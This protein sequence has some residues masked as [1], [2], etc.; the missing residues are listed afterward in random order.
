MNNILQILSGGVRIE[1]FA[2]STLRSKW[3]NRSI[4][5]KFSMDRYQKW[6]IFQSR[7]SPSPKAHDFGC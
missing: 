6:S 4:S 7:N 2:V 3:V 5:Q 1:G